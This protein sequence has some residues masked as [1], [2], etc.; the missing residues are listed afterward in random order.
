MGEHIK[1]LNTFSIRDHNVAIEL[2]KMDI[3]DQEYDIHIEA[4]PFRYNMTDH[5]FMK[6]VTCV[7][8]AKR[9]LEYKKNGYKFY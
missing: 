9:K 2:N 5:E 8:D 4:P 3:N 1:D 7:A 6:I